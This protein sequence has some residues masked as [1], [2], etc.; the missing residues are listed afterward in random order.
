[1]SKVIHLTW[2]SRYEQNLKFK[3]QQELLGDKPN[4]ACCGIPG[5]YLSFKRNAPDHCTTCEKNSDCSD[6][7]TALLRD[8]EN[9]GFDC[10]GNPKIHNILEPTTTCDICSFNQDCGDKI[11]ADQ[12]HGRRMKKVI[13]PDA[14]KV[15]IVEPSDTSVA[16]IP[17]DSHLEATPDSATPSESVRTHASS[18]ISEYRFPNEDPEFCKSL[19]KSRKSTHPANLLELLQKISFVETRVDRKLS[20]YDSIR[21][22]VCAISVALNELGVFPP[23]IRDTRRL[24]GS[25][26]GKKRPA[27]DSIISNDLQV[28]DAHWAACRKYSR[29]VARWKALQAHDPFLF[30]MASEFVATMGKAERKATLLGLSDREQSD[31]VVLHASHI[32]DFVKGI[33]AGR[34]KVQDRIKS[35]NPRSRLPPDRAAIMP[36]AY[37]A[38]RLAASSPKVGAV[39]MKLLTGAESTPDVMRKCL[40]WLTKQQLLKNG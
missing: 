29:P 12:R 14:E 33:Q 4:P 16:S 9:R 3:K 35:A 28:I 8:V 40:M 30:D 18:S 23:F 10:F 25:P 26:P 24:K 1:M 13:E 11:Y 22:H 19:A 32:K 27:E 2:P 36:D 37:V 15:A 17:D 31:L 7:S 34:K 20:S 39:E 21:P 6:E 38:L 5:E